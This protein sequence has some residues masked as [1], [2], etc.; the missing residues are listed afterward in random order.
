MA[1]VTVSPPSC[2]ENGP[3]G[4]AADGSVPEAV[5]RETAARFARVT[6]LIDAGRL[7]TA[8]Q[9]RDVEVVFQ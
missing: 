6:G 4:L 8:H 2:R 9:P 7:E 5:R 3:V 1:D